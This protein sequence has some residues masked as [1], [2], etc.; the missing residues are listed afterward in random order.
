[1]EQ[2]PALIITAIRE[3]AEE[4]G[5]VLPCNYLKNI[6]AERYR[7]QGELRLVKDSQVLAAQQTPYQYF[8]SRK[9]MM[10]EKRL[11]FFL[12]EL[13]ETEPVLKTKDKIQW[14]TAE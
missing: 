14:V 6:L 3:L 1:M 13:R 10:I 5:F 11:T 8:N 9:K 2:G 4:T 12:A 7:E